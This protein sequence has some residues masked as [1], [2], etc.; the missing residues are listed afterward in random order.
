MSRL[1]LLMDEIAEAAKSAEGLERTFPY[2]PDTLE[3]PALVVPWPD[4]F[5]YDRSYTGSDNSI[6]EIEF[7]LVLV[8]GR[9]AT[10]RSM[11]D[12]IA[13]WIDSEIKDSIEDYEYTHD[14][15]VHISGGIVDVIQLGNVNY[16][17]VVFTCE[18][19]FQA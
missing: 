5:T 17:S 9:G 12:R 1:A 10:V 2:P 14:H 7:P 6:D 8:I 11:R 18:V 13:K 16:L 4:T 15:V 3:P 19:T